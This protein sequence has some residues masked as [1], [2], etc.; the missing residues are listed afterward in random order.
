MSL[1][2]Q[3]FLLQIAATLNSVLDLKTASAP[4]AYK[5]SMTLT[6]GTGAD[7]ADQIWDDERTLTTGAN[8]D[9]DLTGTALQNAFGTNIAFARIKLL[10]IVSDPANT[11]N[12]TVGNAASNGWVGP[13]GAATHTI[14]L[15][16]K[17]VL[18]LFDPSSGAYAVTAGT[19]DLLRVT[20]A[21]GASAKYRIILI[22][23][24]V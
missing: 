21:A 10:A 1:D 13:F 20:N 2:S 6:T 11:T 4:L 19:G 5:N 8:E 17:G 15:K 7:Q 3:S 16:P 9:L 18:F 24:T 22:G 14:T 12:L 23:S